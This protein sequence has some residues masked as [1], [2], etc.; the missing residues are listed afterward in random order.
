MP[1]AKCQS[2]AAEVQL[3]LGVLIAYRYTIDT[4]AQGYGQRGVPSST[5][6]T[7]LLSVSVYLM[8]CTYK[9]ITSS[10]TSG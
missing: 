9:Y 6:G 7:I 8:C 5:S 3:G 2:R 4:K 10:I 1:N